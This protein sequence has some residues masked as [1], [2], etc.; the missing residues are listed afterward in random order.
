MDGQ[1][2][3]RVEQVTV[4][5]VERVLPRLPHGLEPLPAEAS[6]QLPPLTIG[7]IVTATIIDQLPGGHYRLALAGM[8]VEAMAPAGLQSGTELGLQ[9]AQLKPEATLHLLP[10]RP[11]V[12]SEVIHLLRTLLPHA[13]PVRGSL[14]TPQQELSRTVAHHPQEEVPRTLATL[15]DFLTHLLPE[16]APP[17]AERLHAFVRDGGLQYESKLSQLVAPPAQALSH[18]VS[19]DM[20]ALLLQA[21]R[22]MES[23][24]ER[25]M[26][27]R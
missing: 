16:D 3:Q 10:P 24:T 12:E 18:V 23:S 27:R 21:M 5:V 11:G 26:P 2:I 4:N 7:Q 9:V 6:P 8:V 19:S 22:Q 14:S 20:K 1:P 13:T 25:P 17:T 15:H